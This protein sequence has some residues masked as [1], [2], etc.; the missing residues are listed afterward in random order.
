MDARMTNRQN[1]AMRVLHL[2]DEF[3]TTNTGVAATVSQLAGWQA[4]RVEWVGI[5]TSGEVNIPIPEGVE[6][7]PNSVHSWTPRWRYPVNGLRNLLRVLREHE[8]SHLHVH[9]AWQAGFVLGM[10]AARKEEL[11][12]VLSVHGMWSPAALRHGGWANQL[13]KLAYWKLFGRWLM[14]SRAALHAIT[15]LEALHIRAFAGR[16]EGIV[17]PN[18]IDLSGSASHQVVVQKTPLKQVIYLGRLHPIKGPDLLIKAFSDS[19][20][21]SG[22]ELVL[23]GPDEVPSYVRELKTQAAASRKS[24]QI[25]FVGPCYGLEKKTLLAGAWVVVVPSH[26]EVVG[27]VNLEAASLY[28]P[29]ITTHATGLLKWESGGGLLSV[30]TSDGLRMALNAVK[31]WSSEERLQRGKRVR[32]MVETEFSLDTVG[33]AWLRFYWGL[34]GSTNR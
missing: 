23:A 27:M 18:A 30:T 13:K 32:H 34:D 3:S 17:L 12:V 5:W 31:E 24:S 15:P 8:V 22:W 20:L 28:T 4:A 21:G 14:L 2:I 10:L 7:L 26:S 1:S 19:E 6:L 25:R 33:F 11:P 29:T 16:S 9:G